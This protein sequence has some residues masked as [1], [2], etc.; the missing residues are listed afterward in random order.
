MALK[1]L[2]KTA[3]KTSSAVDYGA[4]MND[5]KVVP[6]T[7][8]V[9]I[10]HL[11]KNK[12]LD[13]VKSKLG[14]TEVLHKG[15]FSPKASGMVISVEGG[16]TMNMGNYESARIGVTITVPCDMET[17]PEAYEW[18]TDWVSEKMEEAVKTAKGL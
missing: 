16:R 15:V 9:S 13:P 12:K 10:E 17:L 4:H 14:E 6:V 2:E 1:G 18:A 8:S 5:Q 7:T 3:N 11:D